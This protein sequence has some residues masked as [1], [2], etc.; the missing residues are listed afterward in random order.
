MEKEE[1]PG[2]NACLHVS[3]WDC[4][5]C[6]YY[7]VLLTR[8]QTAALLSIFLPRRVVWNYWQFFHN[9]LCC[10]DR[11]YI[12][13]KPL[14][15]L[16]EEMIIIVRYSVCYFGCMYLCSVFWDTGTSSRPITMK[17]HTNF[18]ACNSWDSVMLLLVGIN[19]DTIKLHEAV[20]PCNELSANDGN[21]CVVGV[22]CTG[23]SLHAFCCSVER[24]TFTKLRSS[25]RRKINIQSSVWNWT[26]WNRFIIHIRQ[27]KKPT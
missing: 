26:L 15:V 6:R 21:R 8:H 7:R 5:R 25:Y 2:I 22:G 18:S 24:C 9:S 23:L 4:L 13:M 10:F 12:Q 14:Q 3:L 20:N 16:Q 27:E 17:T 11:E 19:P 1:H